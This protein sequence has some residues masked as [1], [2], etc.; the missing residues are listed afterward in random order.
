[1]IVEACH[2]TLSSANADTI[3][4]PPKKVHVLTMKQEQH[5]LNFDANTQDTQLR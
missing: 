1:L 5:Q 2:A 4:S 3:C